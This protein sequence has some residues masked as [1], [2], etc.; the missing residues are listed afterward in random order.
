MRIKIIYTDGCNPDFIMLCHM[1][2]AYLNHIIG[3]EKNRSQYI[4][5]NTLEY[6][7]DVIISYDEDIPIGCISFKSYENDIAEV[8]RAFV[9]EEYHGSGISKELLNCIEKLA[10]E[11]ELKK[12]VLESGAP[13]VEAMSLY[14]A[15]GYSII[16]NHGPYRCMKDSIC[17]EKTL[18]NNVN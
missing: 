14:N 16:E 5:Y 2:D 9:K 15:S 3:C 6:I 1:L 10:K 18:S 12:L 4:Q 17:M 13:L 8:K 11:K 7:H